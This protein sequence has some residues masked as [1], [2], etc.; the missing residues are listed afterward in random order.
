MIV[1]EINSPTNA[2]LLFRPINEVVR[3]RFEPARLKMKD[4]GDLFE[5][6]PQGIPGQR[7]ELD[8]AKAVGVIAEPLREK[9]HADTAKAVRRAC[10]VRQL[11][12][13]DDG[14]DVATEQAGFIPPAR[15]EF[16]N[17]HAPSWAYW[18]KRAVQSE[19][20]KLV[21]GT[22]AA[23]YPDASRFDMHT[24]TADPRDAKI[25]KLTGT[26]NA[27]AALLMAGL[28]A[29]KRKELDKLLAK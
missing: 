22:F 18:M 5:L 26:V 6:F 15:K 21:S 10:R 13:T 4:K 14:T 3:G 20:A 17:I 27:L 8:E 7:I 12:V 29:D 1:I 11:G 2:D 24:P 16:S 9:C 25:D 19:Q 28:P 23:E